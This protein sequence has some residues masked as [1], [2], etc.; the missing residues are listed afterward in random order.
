LHNFLHKKRENLASV[1]GQTD[2]TPSLDL[3]LDIRNA[4][5]NTSGS[6]KAV[7]SMPLRNFI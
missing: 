1:W 2:G 5:A 4:A 6:P 3:L 7:E